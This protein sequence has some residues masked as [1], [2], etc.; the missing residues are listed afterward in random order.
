MGKVLLVKALVPASIAMA[1]LLVAG[2]SPMTTYGTGKTPAAQ[3]FEDIGGIVSLGG[4]R[5]DAVAIDYKERP[6][7]VEP[8][9][10]AALPPPETRDQTAMTG[11]WVNDP[12]EADKRAKKLVQEAVAFGEDLKF[13]VPGGATASGTSRLRGDR[14]HSKDL[15]EEKREASASPEDQKQVMAAMKAAK[16]GSVDAQGNPVRK[17]LTEPPVDYRAPDPE[18]PLAIPEEKKKGFKWWPF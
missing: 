11:D 8:P 14:S 12:D 7:V 9:S 10:T 13:S 17:Y 1:G 16:N 18:A 4:K 2:C 15:R 6:P 5:H 3:T